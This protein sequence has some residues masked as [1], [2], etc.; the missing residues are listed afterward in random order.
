M[1][2]CEVVNKL[3][4]EGFAATVGRLRQ[5]LM[6]GYLRPLPEKGA[7][8]AYD[9]Q[10]KHLQ[11]LRWYL[12]HVRPGPRPIFPRRLP[13]RGPEDRVRRLARQ[14]RIEQHKSRERLQQQRR[15]QDANATIE[16]LERLADE[17]AY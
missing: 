7:R 5:A 6:N 2:L 10:P 1:T 14:K 12:V 15:R 13:I 16:W 11:Q 17:L 9:F 8:G 4:E 3:K